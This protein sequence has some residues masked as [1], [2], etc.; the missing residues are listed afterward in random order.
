MKYW[1]LCAWLLLVAPLYVVAQAKP[2]LN[3]NSALPAANLIVPSKPTPLGADTGA[4]ALRYCTALPRLA[5]ANW[6]DDY[7]RYN[8]FLTPE[9]QRTQVGMSF[10][11]G[12]VITWWCRPSAS[13][14]AQLDTATRVAD[15]QQLDGR[16]R[17]V[18]CRVIVHRDSV[19]FADKFIYRSINLR[20]INEQDE[21]DLQDGHITMRARHSTDVPMEKIGRKK[22]SVVNGRYL[23]VYGLLKAGAAISQV[24]LDAQGRLILHNCSVT[25]RQIKGRYLTYETIINQ[26][27]LERLPSP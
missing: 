22:Y 12:N 2:E 26:S 5:F 6:E 21:I 20:P 7:A 27:I 1:F 23:L 8:R 24:G 16:W 17:S 15:A 9:I 10:K 11:L 3:G 19:V 25:E 14:H 4:F 13:P 18:S